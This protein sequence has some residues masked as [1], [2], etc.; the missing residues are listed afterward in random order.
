M[1]VHIRGLVCIML[2]PDEN[3]KNNYL[4]DK[5]WKTKRG[6]EPLI[7]RTVKSAA[8]IIR[9]GEGILGQG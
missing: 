7:T 6:I 9:K 3:A 1:T 4:G 5:I 2:F 8:H